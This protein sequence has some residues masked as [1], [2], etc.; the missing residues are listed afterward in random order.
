MPK[1]EI[2]AEDINAVSV[3]KHFQ[4][5]PTHIIL[6]D[7]ARVL[8][9]SNVA[10]FRQDG[11]AMKLEKQ[12]VAD[13]RRK[14]YKGEA[15]CRRIINN[16]SQESH[17]CLLKYQKAKK[18]SE[19]L[20][21]DGYISSNAI[22]SMY[23][24]PICYKGQMM[25]LYMDSKHYKHFD[26]FDHKDL[27]RYLL[28]W[29]PVLSLRLA[30]QNDWLQTRD[31]SKVDHDI[32]NAF[33]AV[34]YSTE[35]MKVLWESIK[36]QGFNARIDTDAQILIQTLQR[37][38]EDAITLLDNLLHQ[39][40]PKL[41]SGSQSPYFFDSP[42]NRFIAVE[43]DYQFNLC[44]PLESIRVMYQAGLAKDKK[45]SVILD[46]I[47]PSDNYEVSGAATDVT[48]A[49]ENFM[50]NAIK[51]T[52]NQINLG[53]KIENDTGH[54]VIVT[55][56]VKDNGNSELAAEVKSFSATK[57]ANNQ[58]VGTGIG[59][60]NVQAFAQKHDGSF[61]LE[62]CEG[63]TIAKLTI[64]LPKA[65]YRVQRTRSF[66]EF[67][68]PPTILSPVKR[69]DGMDEY[70]VL[71]I[72]DNIV[73]QKIYESFGRQYENVIID[74][75]DNAEPKLLS[76]LRR[77]ICN[78]DCLIIDGTIKSAS[79]GTID[80]VTV[81]KSLANAAK[82]KSHDLFV[83]YI[84]AS[85]LCNDKPSHIDRALVKPVLL[86]DIAQ[87]ISDHAVKERVVPSP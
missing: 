29:L 43:Q 34:M 35:A 2:S 24:L 16:I 84:S 15:F 37:T 5:C 59:F 17:G 22:R 83:L 10:Y 63:G 31:F 77:N 69:I 48:K 76:E 42:D 45:I 9:V 19:I 11:L 25:A 68:L 26:N 44:D 87:V 52:D 82:L 66:L 8:H 85:P 49:L 4:D 7:I 40:S 12:F 23:V 14:E 78:Y 62:K 86:K 46:E 36:T 41:E 58:I 13:Q 51:Y 80:G 28:S 79:K 57:D 6:E 75:Y 30:N 18:S 72:E 39:V 81:A 67:N 70:R 71:A 54:D 27:E 47:N 20:Y 64:S 61:S 56:W 3:S 74:V 50:S 21:Y 65:A 53:L 38:S 33:Q 73:G 60:T 32:R 55:Y 1:Y